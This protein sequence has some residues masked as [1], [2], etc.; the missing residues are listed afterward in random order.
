M[1]KPCLPGAAMGAASIAFL[2]EMKLPFLIPNAQ[3]L[4]SY[5]ASSALSIELPHGL[6]VDEFVEA[7]HHLERRPAGLQKCEVRIS[8][9]SVEVALDVL[10]RAVQDI[11]RKNWPR[12]N[13]PIGLDDAL[14]S[15]S[16]LQRKPTGPAT[17]SC[18][19]S[20]CALAP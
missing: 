5:E 17:I 6:V 9:E 7:V 15:A 2:K 19:L 16:A 11:E 18:C 4:C 1:D 8:H 14:Y 3:S 12:V 10:E 20:Q 13:V